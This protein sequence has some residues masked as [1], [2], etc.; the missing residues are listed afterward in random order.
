MGQ[1]GGKWKTFITSKSP[2]LATASGNGRDGRGDKSDN[3]D[4]SHGVRAGIRVRGVEENLDQRRAGRGLE[5]R[6]EITKSEA[7]SD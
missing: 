6:V 1:D 7:E 5:D 2:E 4:S 3:D